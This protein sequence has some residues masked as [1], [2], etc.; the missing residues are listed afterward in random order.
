M[1]TFVNVWAYA[2]YRLARSECLV[3]FQCEQGM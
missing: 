1:A 2:L 3:V